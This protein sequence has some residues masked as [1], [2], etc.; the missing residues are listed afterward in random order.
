MASEVQG[1]L[2]RPGGGRDRHGSETGVVSWSFLY[3]FCSY[4]QVLKAWEA[5]QANGESGQ[6]QLRG[7]PELFCQTPRADLL[8]H[9]VMG[10]HLMTGVSQGF[11]LLP[12]HGLTLLPSIWN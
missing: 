8:F 5:L 4:E 10:L 11:F 2:V 12:R 1:G 6:N 3:A 7:K 9:T